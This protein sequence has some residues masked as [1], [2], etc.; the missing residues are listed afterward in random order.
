MNLWAVACHSVV[1][2]RKLSKVSSHAGSLL[3]VSPSGACQ[4]VALLLAL[5]LPGAA[6]TA[7][8]QITVPTSFQDYAIVGESTVSF[9]A[10]ATVLGDVYGA[11]DITLGS[12]YGIQRPSLNSGNFYTRGNFIQS[13]GFPENTS[14]AANG[15]VTVSPNGFGSIVGPVQYGG[16]V[17]GSITGTTTHV[18][19][20]VPVVALPTAPTFTYGSQKVNAPGNLTL[21]PGS[22]G[23][24]SFSGFYPSLTLSSGD[25]YLKSLN[26]GSSSSVRT[27]NLNITNGPIRVFSDGDIS[28]GNALD[29]YVNGVKINTNITTPQAQGSLASSVL[30]ESNHNINVSGFI[31]SFVGTLFAPNGSVTLDTQEWYGSVL[32]GGP[33]NEKGYLI[34]ESYNFGNA[35]VATFGA[36]D[37]SL[38][39]GG[40]SS[41]N[42]TLTNIAAAGGSTL[43]FTASGQVASGG[44]NLG[45]LAPTTGTVAPG[46]STPMTIPVTGTSVGQARVAVNINDPNAY[47]PNSTGY[48]TVNVLDHASSASVAGAATRAMHGST[49]YGTASIQ[50]VSA[51]Y[52]AGLQVKDAGGLLDVAPGTVIANGG[53]APVR[54][55]LD[56]SG[57]GPTTASYTVKVSDDKSL[58]GAIDLPDQQVTVAGNILDNRR[59]TAGSV[60]L[61]VVHSGAAASGTATLS[62]TGD[63][64]QFT[65]ITVN[66]STA[67]DAN[68][69]SVSGSTSS[70]RF[71]LD[72]MSTTRTVG[73]TPLG[74]GALAGTI[75]LTTNA[76]ANVSGTQTLANVA[77]P[78]TVKVFSG[79]AAWNGSAAGVWGDHPSWSDKLSN[80]GAGAPG[81]SGYNTDTATF[82]NAIGNKAAN[83]AL[84]GSNPSLASLTFDNSQGGSYTLSVGTGGAISIN[85]SQVTVPINDN[86]GS[87][88]I[89]APV[90]LTGATSI[91]VNNSSDTLTIDGALTSAAGLIK[92]GPGTLVLAAVSNGLG[93]VTISGGTL[94]GSVADLNNSIVNNGALVFDQPVD[95]TFGGTVTG[96]GGITKTGA[97]RMTLS[98]IDNFNTNVPLTVSGG[99]L[100]IPA[101]LPR[102]GAA[103]QLT[104]GGTLEAANSVPRAISGT[105]TLLA[106]DDLTVGRSSQTGQFNLGGPAGIGGALSIG[107][108]AMVVLS[109]DAAILGSLTTI[110]D[111]GS[112]TTVNGAQ[113]GL[114]H[115]L[116]SSKILTAF[117]NA[118]INGD[119]INNG[120]VNG[121]TQSGQWLT[122]TQ[123]VRGAGNTTG[124][125]L[126]AGSYSPGNSPNQV[127]VGNV[128]FD[129]TSKLI[130]EVAGASTGEF[131]Q[132]LVGGTANLAGTLDLSLLNGYSLELGKAYP[133]IVG[134]YSGR[135]DQVTGLPGD[136]HLSYQDAG[137]S[138]VPE[139]STIAL[140][141]CSLGLMCLRI[142]RKRRV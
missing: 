28:F 135:F 65:R 106:T 57:Y 10:Y 53:S 30:F 39:I 122:F 5:L 91:N 2:S 111:R 114:A 89:S 44:L 24:V 7:V 55:A 92:T 9:G 21:S 141:A 3:T 103:I 73:G 93:P 139:P 51:T 75:N 95:V 108:H 50:D 99:S 121:P 61:G 105:G 97:G 54:G 96:T 16:T 131:D 80:A 67:A 25:Y 32:A 126:Y 48:A 63:D 12:G 27:L 104:T 87:H 109:S 112:L 70:F 82:G 49:A 124:N 81:I 41:V 58:P 59:V 47:T 66:N 36:P 17:S 77:V 78:Y 118:E 72:G 45:A 132:L 62:T 136:W 101:G 84:N 117:G 20:S 115:S 113:L 94:R 8:G 88:R 46:A 56:T 116:D 110:G 37:T 90:T 60:D 22:Y 40:S 35:A 129:A 6:G 125:V 64:S 18:Q 120:L 98:G 107:N 142:V 29:V 68:G 69:I 83:I 34:K 4:G 137:V 71:G 76:E 43:N 38:I 15:N 74:L 26:A 134:N 14:V 33:I 42:A 123:D 130:M 100:V 52:R 11:G 1:T 79:Q 119:F 140:T 127:S 13:S 23:D 86:N 85:A 19:N 102:G 133:L 128:A 31:G 138:L